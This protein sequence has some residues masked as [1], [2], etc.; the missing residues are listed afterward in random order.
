MRYQWVTNLWAHDYIPNIIWVM[1]PNFVGDVID[2]IYDVIN[3]ISK[4]LY[5]K[6][7]G[8]AIFTDFIK[9]LTIFFITIFKDSRKV[10]MNRNYVSKC[11]LYLYFLIYQNLLIFG[12]QMLIT[13]ELKLCVTWFIY[14]LDLL[15]IRYDCAKFRSCRIFATDFRKGGLFAPPPSV[16]SPE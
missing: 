7:T 3:F 12:E 6:K 9:T 11:N 5:F 13:A 16:S 10:K 4:C 14:F 15:W 8:V 2:R 1:W